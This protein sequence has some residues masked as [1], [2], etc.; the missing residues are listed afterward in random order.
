MQ[1]L[2]LHVYGNIWKLSQVQSY[3][4]LSQ[5]F[6]SFLLF[7]FFVYFEM[8]WYI[9]CFVVRVH[10]LTVTDTVSALNT[11]KSLLYSNVIHALLHNTV[12]K[13]KCL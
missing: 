8:Y 3:I 13:M 5:T 1:V 12:N 4:Y 6:Y 11:M 9:T 2:V 7:F 10:F